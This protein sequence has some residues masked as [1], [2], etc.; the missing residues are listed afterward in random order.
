M[1]ADEALIDEDVR[2]QVTAPSNSKSD[3]TSRISH[4]MSFLHS[5]HIIV[6]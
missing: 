4:M 5:L 1:A 6:S 3:R 2:A